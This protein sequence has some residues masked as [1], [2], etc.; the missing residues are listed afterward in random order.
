MPGRHIATASP[1]LCDSRR[2]VRPA[3]PGR[4][5][6]HICLR[7]LESDRVVLLRR[8]D[9]VP[10]CDQGSMECQPDGS[11]LRPSTFCGFAGGHVDEMS[12]RLEPCEDDER[13]RG[14]P[15]RGPAAKLGAVLLSLLEPTS[16]EHVAQT[17]C[18]RR[19]AS[20]A[21]SPNQAGA[22]AATL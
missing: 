11:T 8:I 16:E 13:P 21:A 4:S 7:P 14:K 18:A 17:P 19:L 10:G 22:E 20:H 2:S 1:R 6:R 15:F 9:S 3:A 12:P 5:T